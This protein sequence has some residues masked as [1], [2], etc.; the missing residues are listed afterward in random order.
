[1]RRLL[2]LRE[3]LVRGA[4]LVADED[5]RHA[6]QSDVLAPR[7]CALHGLEQAD[8]AGVAAVSGCVERTFA[9]SSETCDVR[10]VASQVA[11]HVEVAVVRRRVQG[12]HTVVRRVVK[13]CFVLVEDAHD[14]EVAVL[15]GHEHGG[16]PVLVREV[17]V[18]PLVGQHAHDLVVAVLRGHE[19]GGGPVLV[20]RSR[21][22]PL[23]ASTRT[24][25][26]WPFCAA[27]N[28]GV[29]PSSSRG[30]G[31]PPCRP[32]RARPRGGRS[33]RP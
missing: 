25:S 11:D 23:S 31:W 12:C 32:A 5:V 16:G 33:A 20:A 19:H 1:M 22:A 21:F 13:T 30:R 15:R 3:D 10:P 26:W 6:L 24:T 14:L 4:D 7:A 8:D 28:T 18:G 9:A 27:M 29:A 17:E 2:R